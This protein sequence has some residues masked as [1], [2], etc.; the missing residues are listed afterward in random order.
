MKRWLAVL[1]FTVGCATTPPR[2]EPP[3][4]LVVPPIATPR[5]KSAEA[6]SPSKP[7]WE[8]IL[9]TIPSRKKTE[10]DQAFNE[11]RDLGDP[12]SADALAAFL[13]KD[14]HPH[15]KTLAAFALAELGDLR[16]APV[17]AWRLGKE[18]SELYAADDEPLWM[19]D[20]NERI[21]AARLLG[22][23]ATIHRDHRAELARDAE[24]A[25]L[26]WMDSRPQPHA[27]AMRFL[28]RVRSTKGIAKLRAWADPKEPLPKPGGTTFPL[29][30]AVA[31]SALR[32]LGAASPDTMGRGLLAKQLGRRPPNV[33]V[34]MKTL[35]KGGNALEAMSIRALT[36][37]AAQG[38]AE[39]HDT[40]A[41][42]A[43]VAFAQDPK[44]NEQVRLEACYAIGDIARPEQLLSLATKITKLEETNVEKAL[45]MACWLEAILRN[46][47]VDLSSVLGPLVAKGGDPVFVEKA[48]AALVLEGKESPASVS[49][50]SV[51][52]SRFMTVNERDLENGT[53][54]RQLR[55]LKT[56]E[57]TWQAVR[58][59]LSELDVE[60]GP[61]TISRVVARALLVRDARG[62]DPKK[63]ED[64][65]FVLEAM[66]AQTTVEALSAK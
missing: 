14:P 18:P 23:L 45:V 62:G 63:R 44:N 64:A 55:A 33:D 56:H 5:P 61:N 53:L 4:P 50:P 48:K 20:D 46:P 16:A 34:S 35:V 8:K 39:A 52:A 2:P 25:V 37:G 32:W 42:P 17:L 30:F 57:P 65:L 24:D 9:S 7:A 1:G 51:V 47:N 15:A 19:R 26:A 13:A 27:N 60:L 29:S 58:A 28:A 21:V 31:Q 3:Q 10:I 43:L 66:G 38:F 12:R 11:L 40:T 22:D 41:V 6:A 59:S 36:S 49:D 54:A